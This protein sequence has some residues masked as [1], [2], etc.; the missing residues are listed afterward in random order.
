MSTEQQTMVQLIRDARDT[1]ARPEYRAY[2]VRMIRL[3]RST[4]DTVSVA[5]ALVAETV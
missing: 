1:M 4:P 2:I 5:R 3:Y